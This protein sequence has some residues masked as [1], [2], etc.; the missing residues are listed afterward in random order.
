MQGGIVGAVGIAAGVLAGSVICAIIA[1]Y[2]INMPGGGSV[3]YLERLPVETNW[4]LALVVIPSVALALCVIASLYPARQAAR[5][6]PVEA[7]RYE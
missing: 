7:I 2:P 3:Y 1:V 5:L 4:F 6:D